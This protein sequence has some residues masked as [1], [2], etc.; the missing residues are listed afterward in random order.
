MKL[1]K[2]NYGFVGLFS[3]AAIFNPKWLVKTNQEEN[4][5]GKGRHRVC[6]KESAEDYLETIL[7]LSTKKPVVRSAD[8][9]QEMGVSRPSVCNAMKNLRLGGYI[10][11]NRSK[12]IRLTDTGR[13]I[14]ESMY[15]RHVLFSGLLVS[16]GVD[17]RVAVT[18]ACR[19]EHVL[20][21]ESFQALRAFIQYSMIQN[22]NG[23]QQPAL[24]R[25]EA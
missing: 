19:M 18:D 12:G 21:E 7:V 6:I 23:M 25:K 16:F 3:G 17:S 11:M 22:Q 13:K 4:R 5:L 20:S 1:V 8:I 10:E 9:A 2:T 14:A 24:E 15:E